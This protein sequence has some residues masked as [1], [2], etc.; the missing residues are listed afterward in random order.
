MSRGLARGLVP[1]FVPLVPVFTDRHVPL[2]VTQELSDPVGKQLQI[3]ASQD[4][5]LKLHLL[6]LAPENEFL[7]AQNKQL[8]NL[9]LHV[10]VR[11]SGK[12]FSP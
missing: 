11:Y 6:L 12:F 1:L 10:N 7:Y 5:V 8:E 9:K 4:A 3:S 2:G